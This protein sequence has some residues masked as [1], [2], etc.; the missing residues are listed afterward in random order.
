MVSSIMSTLILGCHRPFSISLCVDACRMDTCFKTPDLC[1]LGLPRG[2]R[3]SFSSFLFFISLPTA[4]VTRLVAPFRGCEV[5]PID[6]KGGFDD[7]NH[8]AIDKHSSF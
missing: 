7:Q 5:D 8:L 2:S 1:V 4:S 3:Y 6:R